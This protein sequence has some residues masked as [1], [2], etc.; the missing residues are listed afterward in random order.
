MID[1]LTIKHRNAKTNFDKLTTLPAVC[2]PTNFMKFFP[3]YPLNQKLP[4]PKCPKHRVIFTR[5]KIGNSVSVTT[6]I[7]LFE[8]KR[9]SFL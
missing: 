8:T 5:S 3:N 1:L 6:I 9:T 7:N 4:L 2:P